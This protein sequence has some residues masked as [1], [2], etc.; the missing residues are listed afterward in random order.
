MLQYFLIFSFLLISTNAAYDYYKLSQQWPP[1]FCA[2]NKCKP[3]YTKLSKFTI[4]GL[5]P[6][7]YTGARPI[8]CKIGSVSMVPLTQ[9]PTTLNSALASNWPNLLSKPDYE[10]WTHEWEKHG[11]CSSLPNSPLD[12]FRLALSIQSKHNLWN[13]LTAATFVPNR[14]YP[15]NLYNMTIFQS[16]GAY[17]ELSCLQDRKNNYH[18]LEMRLCLDHSGASYINCT[19]P[20]NTCG[21]NINWPL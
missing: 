9:I 11:R 5:W 7:N 1:T 10:F 2:V 12:Y 18:L 3:Q 14:T 17:P 4:H 8:V 6:S 15:K 21:T 13:I 20:S 16:T 19:D